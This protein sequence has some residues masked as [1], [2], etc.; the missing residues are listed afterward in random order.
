M[1]GTIMLAATPDNNQQ[2]S[3]SQI[4]EG[5]SLEQAEVTK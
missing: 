3:I 5:A 4:P 1:K 2:N